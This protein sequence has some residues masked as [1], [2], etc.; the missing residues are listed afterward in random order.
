[1]VE[2]RR[3]SNQHYLIMSK[4]VYLFGAGS[5]Y[6]QRDEV[7]KDIIL[8][9]LPILSEFPKQIERLISKIQTEDTEVECQYKAKTEEINKLIEDLK[10]LKATSESH[11][12]V[13]TYAKKLW[14][15]EKGSAN[16]LKF[17]AALS[18]FLTLSQ[19]FNKPDSRYDAFFASIIGNKY[20]E[21]ADVSILSWNY[22]CQF[23]IA[24]A[25]YSGRQN[26]NAIWEDLK[27]RSKRT[28]N[29]IEEEAGF[30][31]TK[32][33]GTALMFED[34]YFVSSFFDPYFNR[35]GMS[36]L[37]YIC[38]LYSN[39][40]QSENVRNALSFAWESSD[41]DFKNLIQSKVQDAEVLVIIGYSFP[42]F[43]R[44]ID[45]HIVRNMTN[46]KKVYIQDPNSHDVKEAFEATLSES[47][48]AD[49]TIK[50]VL[51]SGVSQFLIPNEM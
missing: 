35:Q 8:E 48:L 18:A 39:S 22:D 17:K 1:M 12:T 47:Q 43:N 50:Y 19:L 34:K 13:D 46:L 25:N 26:I 6:G 21:L 40:P 37:S 42:Y 9:G 31:L 45:R 36:E 28:K 51:K 3:I 32:L 7:D 15:I 2:K 23:E 30:S 29:T 5:S 49:N 16:Y 4:I 27:I 24:H 11:K 41:Y 38:R 44:E 10:W 33:N 20:W 14:T